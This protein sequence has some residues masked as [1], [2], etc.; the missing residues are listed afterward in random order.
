MKKFVILGGGYGGLTIALNMLEKDLPEDTMLV[1]VD[2]SPFQG[3]KTEYYALA[4]GTIA[5]THIRVAYPVDP[6]LELTYGEVTE[7]DLPNKQILFAD[8][9]PLTYDWLAIGLGCVD[10]YHGIVGAEEY[11]HSIQTLSQTRATYQRVNDIAPYG[12]ISIIGG[13]LSGVEMAAELR[14]SRPDL[15]IRLIDRG[16]SLLSSFPSNLQQYVR[17]WMVEH[18]IELRPQV[19]LVRLDGGELYNQEEIIKTDVTIWTAGIQ[20]TPIVQALNV[21]KDKQGR[22]LLNEFHQIPDYPEVYVVGDCASLP[23]SPSAQ[24]AQAQGKQIA[25]AMQSIWKGETPRLGKI[26]LRGTLGSLGK[27]SGFGIMGKRTLMTGK[28]ARAIKSGVLWKS[29]RHFG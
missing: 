9:E 29:K 13:G 4:S 10:S 21:P 22:I 28:I 18:H 16:P 7:V 3:L 27:K 20:P 11:S 1:L 6:R 5:E 2:R 15:N 26:K 25:E 12:Q 14:E 8:K 24:A 23:F 17:D 19:S